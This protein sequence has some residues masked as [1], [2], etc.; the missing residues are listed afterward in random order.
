MNTLAGSVPEAVPR[1]RVVLR[2][3]PGQSGGKCY[4][5]L[6]RAWQPGGPVLAAVH[7]ISRNAREQALLF[8]GWAERHGFAVIAPL[9]ARD[10]YRDYQRLGIEARGQRADQFFIRALDAFA[11]WAGGPVARVS[12]FGYSGGGQFA[13]RF[14]LLHP[15]RV[16]GLALGA[17]GWYTL[18]DERRAFPLGI[19][20]FPGEDQPNLA[21]WL[22]LP[23]IVLVGSED[24]QRDPALRQSAR[25]DRL[26]GLTR[27]ERGQRFIAATAAAARK[28][29]VVPRLEFTLLPGV[30]HSF[31]AAM[32]A[33]GLPEKIIH[34]LGLQG[35]LS[36]ETDDVR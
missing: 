20:E 33:G 25:L 3:L 12:L 24:N 31:E 32:T 18:P 8:A 1:G 22:T 28:R 14:A 26:Q 2:I 9:F 10:S 30:A 7:G 15:S 23:M 27:I 5:Y 4:V 21:A 13:H 17:P 11:G 6:P 35:P 29:G 36:L 19:A 34:F 16:A